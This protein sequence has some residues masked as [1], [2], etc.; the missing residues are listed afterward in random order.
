[1]PA[2]KAKGSSESQSERRNLLIFLKLVEADVVCEPQ[3]MINE[4]LLET[5]PLHQPN[6][7]RG[8]VTSLL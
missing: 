4:S 2:N 7:R 6:E 1:M 3:T 5:S 8:Q